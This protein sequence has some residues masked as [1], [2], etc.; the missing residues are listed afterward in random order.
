MPTMTQVQL[1]VDE[2]TKKFSYPLVPTNLP[3]VYA[4][5]EGPGHAATSLITHAL[6][7]ANSPLPDAGRIVPHLE[8]QRGVTHNRVGAGGPA[9][10]AL[11]S[12]NWAGSQI[13]GSWTSAVGQWVVPTVSKAPEAA[14]AGGGWHCST[15]VGI[16]GAYGSSDV[17]QAGVAQQVD[18]AGNVSAVPWY[19]W[20]TPVTKVT[21]GDTSPLSPSLAS[22]NGRLYIAWKG[23]GND[24]LN[25]MYSSDN[26]ATFGNKFVSPETSPQPPALAVH[27]GLLFIAWKG[28]GNDQLN[29]AQVAISGNNITGFVNKRVLGDTSP[30]APALCSFNGRLYLAW[31]G[32]GNDQLNL[33]S[34]G[35]N[36][37]TF[38]NKFV[39]PET[40]PQSP[41]LCTHNGA[42]F[43]GWKG[44]GN[45]NLN[46]AQVAFSGANITGFANKRTLGDTSPVAPSLC[47]FNGRLFLSW[48]GDGN[49]N[50]NLMVSSDNGL[51]FGGKYV[52]PETSPRSPSLTVNGSNLF[53]GWKGD[54]NDNL[55]VSLVGFDGGN[56]DGFTTPGYRLQTNITNLPVS[57]GDT[58]SCSV[59][60]VSNNTAGAL[61]FSNVTTGKHF[62]I[63]I[64]P[65]PGAT[66]DGN[67]AEW[68]AETPGFNNALSSLAKFT[69]INF[70]GCT[71]QGPNTSGN[72]KNGDSTTIVRSGKSL[73]AETLALDAVTITFQG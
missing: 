53:I 33:I 46:V 40:S 34:S 67:C 49:D 60:Y 43:I 62:S 26:G 14:G 31:K 20:F 30:I 68:I 56:I 55:N 11:T 59:A 44:D 36:G 21:L 7:A 69:N 9:D 48:K 27:N 52:S 35:D 10:A 8:P 47:S 37:N 70:S 1:A 71:C 54:G 19:E 61:T 18:T 29:V 73:T 17:L 42:L 16:D 32:D 13:K 72:P 4:S 6:V 25:I 24:Q 23:D 22:L 15:W 28:D 3:G 5:P 63:T 50:L 66:F 57:P 12:G 51:T 58:V 41:A 2:F 39:S 65:P 64:A 38:G 45:D